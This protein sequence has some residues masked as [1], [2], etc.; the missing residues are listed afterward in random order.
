MQYLH[1]FIEDSTEG[2]GSIMKVII[3]KKKSLIAGTLI[4]CFAIVFIASV[5]KLV[6]AA[7]QAAAQNR[8]LPI[9]CVDRS[10]KVASLSFDAA[11]GNVISGI[12]LP[13]HS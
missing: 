2:R 12:E 13:P 7:A 4:L 5:L 11:W 9:Y 8:K 3:L 6:P 10:E 1:I